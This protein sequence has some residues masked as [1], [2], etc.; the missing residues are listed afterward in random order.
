MDAVAV[1]DEAPDGFLQPVDVY[2]GDDEDGV[3]AAGELQYP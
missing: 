2:E 3:G 1:E